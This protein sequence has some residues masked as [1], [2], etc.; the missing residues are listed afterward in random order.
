MKS[1]VTPLSLG[2]DRI[3]SLLVRYAIPS[4]VAMTSSSLY[5][6][7]DSIFIG[8]GVGA[9][10][11]SGL[12]LTMPLM[13]LASAFGAMVG[14]G[15]SAIISIR[16]GQG[17]KLSAE[18]TLGNVVLLNMLIGT[19]FTVASLMFLDPILY[20]FGASDQTIGY[21]RDFMR[22]ILS[23]TIITHMYLG[24]NEV[25]RASGYP[26]K[27]MLI[28]LT[29]VAV[30]C[31]LN[32]LFIFVF[33]WG[34]RG[35]AFATVIAQAVALS[36]SLTHFSSRVSF[37][38]FQRSIFRLRRRIVGGILSIGLAPFLLHMCASVV[39][40]FVNKALKVHGGDLYIGA[41]GIINRVALLFVMIVAGLN[42]GMQPIVGYNYGARKYDRVIRTLRM[43]IFCAV[44]VTTT[45]FLLGHF[46]PRPVAMLFVGGD[47]ADAA[48][49]IDAAAY[50][51]RIVLLLFPIVG[52]QIVTSNFFQYIGKPKKA[53]LL[54]LTRQL[55]FLVPLLILLPPH[56]GVK[57][58]WIAMPIADSIATLLA[59]V[60]LFFQIRKLRRDPLHER[61][62]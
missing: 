45:G 16:L 59:A 22:I 30:N 49:L 32:P 1:A 53:I 57:G 52:F 38:H 29:A 14:I 23:G 40:I 24:L 4:I 27:A 15:A 61:T 37:L 10:A 11:I 3:S 39:V 47:G 44:A 43:T 62:I 18:Q 35:S 6:I 12:A 5:N 34:I 42:Q 21:A 31:T 17:N 25:L 13:N 55:L 46:A 60:L 51:L 56:L 9:L 33:G 2:T 26:R 20:F 7:I 54:S 8:H 28:M 41:Y 19:L 48:G 36:V 50:G 58:V